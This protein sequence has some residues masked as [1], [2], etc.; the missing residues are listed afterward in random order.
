MDIELFRVSSFLVCVR[1]YCILC[2]K[3]VAASLARLTLASHSPHTRLTFASLRSL[4]TLASLAS[5]AS[6]PAV[7]AHFAASPAAL[8]PLSL[9]SCCLPAAGSHLSCFAPAARLLLAHLARFARSSRS[10]CSPAAAR[11]ARFLKPRTWCSLISLAAALLPRACAARFARPAS[12]LPCAARFAH[13]FA[14]CSLSHLLALLARLTRL[15]RLASPAFYS[16]APRWDF[17]F[18]G[19]YGLFSL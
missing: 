8:S 19:S 10:P 9:R 12:R 16:R 15:A 5:L 3:R 2:T 13:R 11:F 17:S 1:V 4:A 18:Y 7:L 14:C 6:S